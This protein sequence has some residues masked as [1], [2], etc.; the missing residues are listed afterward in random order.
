MFQHFPEVVLLPSGRFAMFLVQ[1]LS[2]SQILVDPLYA[3]AWLFPPEVL[4]C[5][6]VFPVKPPSSNASQI[7]C[8]RG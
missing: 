2:H 3:V 1:A 5:S 8:K 4:F 7:P 6:F